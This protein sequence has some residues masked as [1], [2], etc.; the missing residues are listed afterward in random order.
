MKDAEALT[1]VDSY[2]SLLKHLSKD[3]KIRLINKLSASLLKD[4]EKE[5]TTSLADKFYGAWKDDRTAEDIIEDIR[6]SRNFTRTIET[7]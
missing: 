4:M 6:N 2:W 3:V 7:F 1:V 5:D